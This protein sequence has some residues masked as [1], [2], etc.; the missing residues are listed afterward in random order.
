MWPWRRSERTHWQ[1]P[2]LW[3]VTSVAVANAG[4]KTIALDQKKDFAPFDIY[5]FYFLLYS[6]IGI[7]EFY[8][9]RWGNGLDP[10]IVG[11]SMD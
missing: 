9:L 2:E 5:F 11:W 7:K 3:A 8:K 4:E 10:P 1:E 6:T